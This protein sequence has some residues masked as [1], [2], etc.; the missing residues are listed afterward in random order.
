MDD[1][2]KV[3]DFGILTDIVFHRVRKGSQLEHQLLTKPRCCGLFDRKPYFLT[4]FYLDWCQESAFPELK[5][6]TPQY[7]AIAAVLQHI[8]FCTLAEKSHFSLTF[9]HKSP[10]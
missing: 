9:F 3:P 5:K 7:D 10:T 1:I 8:Y 2:E 6:V 4:H